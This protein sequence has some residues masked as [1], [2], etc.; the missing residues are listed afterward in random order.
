MR[1]LHFAS[2]HPNRVHVQLGNFVRRHIEALPHETENTVLHAWPDPAQSLRRREVEDV[3]DAASGIRTLTAY[4]PD[5]APRRWRIDR[6]YTR[7][8]EGLGREGYHPDVVH[9]H[10]AA[11]AAHAAV[12]AAEHWQVPLVVSENWTAYHA[13]HGRSFRPKEERG[14]RC[15]LE[16]ASVHLPVSMHLGRAMAAFAPD[17]KQVVVPNVVIGTFEPPANPRSGDGP[18]RLLHVSS[19]IDVHKD[20]TGMIHAAAMAAEEGIDFTLD[21][22]GGAGAGG[23][24]V[25][26]YRGL[27]HQ[28]GVEKRI[29]FLGPADSHQVM[30]AMQEADAFVLFSRYE[31]LPCVLLEAWMTG[32]PTLATDVGGVGEHLERHPGL[33]TLLQAGDREGLAQA[34]GH[35]ATLKRQGEGWPSPGIADYAR[36]R[37]SPAAVGNS[38][39]E[40]Y[41]SVLG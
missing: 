24:A 40:V 39:L 23:D 35:A 19:L 4:V 18:L 41:R 37:F 2:W 12:D 10:N 31:N 5:R 9:L 38:I 34:I 27:A 22:W 14:V 26:G 28:L 33:G 21:C 36:A 1:V 13:E 29:T 17:I 16:A 11:E 25:N 6:A 15:A 3:T 30:Q 7:L 20:I 32:L 8:V